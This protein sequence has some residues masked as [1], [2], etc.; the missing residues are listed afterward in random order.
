MIFSV[1]GWGKEASCK[2]VNV[3]RLA[4]AGYNVIIP[5]ESACWG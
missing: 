5:H 3:G 4:V 2:D 1:D